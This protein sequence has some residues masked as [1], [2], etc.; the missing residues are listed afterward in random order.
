[1]IKKNKAFFPH[2]LLCLRAVN[3]PIK[4]ARGN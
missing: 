1:M 2:K 4:H 3:L